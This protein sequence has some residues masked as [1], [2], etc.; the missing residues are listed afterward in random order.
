M[1]SSLKNL[2]EYPLDEIP[3]AGGMTFG[4]A[5]T[6]YHNDIT[7][8]LLRGCIETLHKHGAE[9]QNITV[10][11]VPGAFELPLGAQFLVETKEPDA[12]ICLGCVIT[13]E[14]RHDE[15]I[16]NAVSQ[17]IMQL[18]L[19]FNIP[20]IFGVLTPQTLQQAKDRAGGK[21]G[22]KG[23]EAAVT[24]IK[25]VDLKWKNFHYKDLLD[26]N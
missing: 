20:I 8:A 19:D 15:Y 3:A 12:V 16:C 25:M 7:F 6:D 17:G 26:L 23:I 2:S 9:D 5:V 14:T 18:G 24:A 22:N 4:I 1:A 13:G 10:Y 11:H 21:Y